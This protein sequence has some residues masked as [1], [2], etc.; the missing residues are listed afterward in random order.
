MA[1]PK[2][3]DLSQLTAFIRQGTTELQKLRPEQRGI[4]SAVKET[5]EEGPAK[6]E[7]FT[8]NLD[9][10]TIEWAR[11]AVVHTLGLTLSGL[12]EEA[13]ARELSRRE[14]QNGGPFPTSTATPKKGR[15]VKLRGDK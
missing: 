11:R 5:T 10:E 6:R 8:V 15:P 3:K 14:K 7:R 2:K 9:P 4:H 12:V 1:A 13:L